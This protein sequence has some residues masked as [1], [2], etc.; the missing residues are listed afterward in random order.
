M[1]GSGE[2]ISEFAVFGL[3][4]GFLGSLTRNDSNRRLL[5]YSAF[6]VGLVALVPIVINAVHPPVDQGAS[7]VVFG[8]DNLPARGIPV[9]LDRGSGPI[10]RLTTDSTGLFRAPLKPSE[11][12]QSSL[13]ICVPGGVPRLVRPVEHVLTPQRY[14]IAP[15]PADLYLG[16]GLRVGGWRKP[17]VPRECL[18]SPGRGL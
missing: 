9:Y 4:L 17:R 2:L 16:N 1:R 6:M 5:V 3:V 14:E 10:E 15:M 18:V 8:P 13:L 11:Y 7:G 12:R